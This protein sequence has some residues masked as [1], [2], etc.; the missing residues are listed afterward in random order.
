MRTKPIYATV[1]SDKVAHCFT[2]L[3][4]INSIALASE[5]HGMDSS[6]A[7]FLEVV[8]FVLTVAFFFEM[9]LKLSVLGPREYCGDATRAGR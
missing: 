1:Q 2:T 9:V 5:Y 7:T 6:T 3:I 4:V 8:N